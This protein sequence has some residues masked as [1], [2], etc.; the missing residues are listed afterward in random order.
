MRGFLV[1]LALTGAACSSTGAG[2]SDGGNDVV[3]TL[4]GGNGDV[5][6]P[7]DGSNGTC[8]GASLL[9]EL[10]KTKLM[11]GASMQDATAKLAPFDIR[12]VYLSG[13]LFDGNSPCASCASNCTAKGI[14]C[15]N[16]GAGCAWWGC[17]Q[18]DQDPPGAYARNFF[19]TANADGEI[20]MITYYEILHTSGVNEGAPEVTQAAT[21]V[22]VMTRYFADWRFLLQQIGTATVLLHIE[23]D[24]W[25]YAEQTGKDAHQLAAA[26]AS[27]NATDCASQENSIA[28]MGRCMVAMVRKYAPNARVGLHASAWSTNIDVAENTNASFD[29]TVEAKKTAAFLVACGADVSDFV[30]VEASD[31][32]AGYYESIG[33]QSWWDDTNQ[34]LPTFHQDFAWLTALAEA[35]NAPLLDWQ[36]P[37][38]NMS[39][40]NTTNH[41]KDNRVDYFFAHPDELAA[42]H[43]VGFAFGA[44]AGDQTS[45]ETDDGNLVAKTNA[46]HTSGGQKLCP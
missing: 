16:G 29:V 21:D 20:P 11:V 36:L 6:P 32:D 23:P 34:T 35:A 17:W 28:G 9:S 27:A 2:P 12:Y 42:T 13:G 10:G 38:G 31:R 22:S 18:Y 44:G 8:L 19:S 39:L 37:V 7:Y 5:A 15:K 24:F 41:W 40:P 3:T 45:P 26:V 30:V 1:M 25:G 33:R 43:M 46:Y 14:S 4:D